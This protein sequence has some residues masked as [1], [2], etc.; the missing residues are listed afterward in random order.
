MAA[1]INRVV[2]VGNLTRDPEL[3]HTPSGTVGGVSGTSAIDC[4]IRS[5]AA[6]L[7][8]VPISPSRAYAAPRSSLAIPMGEARCTSCAKAADEAIRSSHAMSVDF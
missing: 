8:D 2:L 3:R 4:S 6:R 1:N 7:S 5:T